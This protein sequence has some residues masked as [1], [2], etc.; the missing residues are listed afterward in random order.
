MAMP[1]FSVRIQAGIGMRRPVFR[2][3]IGDGNS[4]LRRQS[5]DRGRRI[6]VKWTAQASVV[7]NPEKTYKSRSS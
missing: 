1:H 7:G 5:D 4:E 6:D 3:D 2:T